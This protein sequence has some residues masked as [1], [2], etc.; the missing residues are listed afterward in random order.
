MSYPNDKGAGEGSEIDRLKQTHDFKSLRASPN[1]LDVY[2]YL[3]TRV[4]IPYITK[5]KIKSR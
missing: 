5:N 3:R 2:M 4:K 1:S